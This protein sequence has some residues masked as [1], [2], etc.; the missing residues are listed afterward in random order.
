MNENFIKKITATGAPITV[1]CGFVPACVRV[2]NLTSATGDNL[3]W[4]RGMAAAS[5]FKTAGSTRSK[6]TTL[7]ITAT[8]LLASDN[9]EQG[10]IIG[11]DAAVNIATND[12]FVIAERGGEGCQF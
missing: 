2:V 1:K 9:A 3:E 5:A 10:F 11:A 7:G 12:L 4:F 6:I 8:G